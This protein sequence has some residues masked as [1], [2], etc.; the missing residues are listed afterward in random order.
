MTQM[1]CPQ[2]QWRQKQEQLDRCW[3]CGQVCCAA[4]SHPDRWGDYEC[5]VCALWQRTCEVM[6]EPSFDEEWMFVWEGLCCLWSLIWLRPM[7]P[8]LST[9]GRNTLSSN[10]MAPTGA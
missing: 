10:V 8:C 3:R 1:V 6:R 7:P 5:Q 2:C 9:A 4:C